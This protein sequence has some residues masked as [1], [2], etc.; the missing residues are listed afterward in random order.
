[1]STIILNCLVI[2]ENPYENAFAVDIEINRSISKFK[3]A[4]KE[5]QK[6]FLIT[7]RPKNSSYRRSTISLKEENKKLITVNTKINV[8]IK[9]ELSGVELFLLSKISKHFSSRKKFTVLQHMGYFQMGQKQA[10]YQ[11]SQSATVESDTVEI[12]IECKVI[13]FSADE[14]L[15][16]IIWIANLKH[17]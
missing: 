15:L 4:I 8:N 13:Q 14:N 12:A 1:M 17:L 6:S 7:L 2:G 5:N 9:D 11:T 16:R 10:Y 3:N